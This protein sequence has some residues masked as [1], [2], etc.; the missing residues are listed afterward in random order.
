MPAREGLRENWGPRSYSSQLG[1]R[2]SSLYDN[3]HNPLHPFT[4]LVK[5]V[6]GEERWMVKRREGKGGNTVVASGKKKKKT[7]GKA[8]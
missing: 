2:F 4:H 3:P 6:R 7:V 5:G 1:S 8:L